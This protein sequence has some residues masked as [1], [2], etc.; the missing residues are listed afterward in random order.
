[1]LADV[2]EMSVDQSGADTAPG[3]RATSGDE[4]QLA[5]MR[6]PDDMLA[7]VFEMSVDQSGADTALKSRATSG[8][9]DISG[10]TGIAGAAFCED[11]EPAAE[12]PIVLSGRLSPRQEEQL[13]TTPS[14]GG[15]VSVDVLDMPVVL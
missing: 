1:M 5:T 2:F 12:S 6:S 13:S 14:A 9:D 11:N 8:D 10:E 7:D 4:T 3:S 15:G